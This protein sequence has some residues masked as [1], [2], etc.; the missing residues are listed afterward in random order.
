MFIS[1]LFDIVGRFL[2]LSTFLFLFIRYVDSA[3]SHLN[4]L[5]FKIS[6]K[7]PNNEIF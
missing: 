3:Y 6:R 2:D 1:R 7:P 5:C 4:S